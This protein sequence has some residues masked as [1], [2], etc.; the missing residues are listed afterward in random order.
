VRLSNAK[1]MNASACR[2]DRRLR[3]RSSAPGRPPPS[4][5]S[6]PSPAGPGRFGTRAR[7]I[8]ARGQAGRDR[9]RPRARG[10]A[11]R[12]LVASPR[13]RGALPCARRAGHS[14]AI[15]PE[16]LEEKLA[17]GIVVLDDQDQALLIPAGSKPARGISRPGANAPKRPD[18]PRTG[19]RGAPSLSRRGRLVGSRKRPSLGVA[20]YTTLRWRAAAFWWR[21]LSPMARG[22]PQIAFFLHP[23]LRT[24]E[25]Y[26]QPPGSPATRCLYDR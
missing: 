12:G 1:K 22:N 19:R 15:G 25:G 10:P 3:A 5:L 26:T 17:R 18:A 2:R 6:E 13:S 24:C 4:D 11:T 7:P 14:E 8:H 9:C 20:A 23:N 16:V 21:C